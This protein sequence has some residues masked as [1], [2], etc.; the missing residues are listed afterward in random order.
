DGAMPFSNVWQQVNERGFPIN[1]VWLSAF[2]AFCMALTSLGI[3]VAYEAML[4]I[5]AIGLYVAYGLPIFFRVTLGRRSFVPGP[6]NM[7]RCGVVVGWIAVLWVVTISV[8]FSLPVSYPVT[9]ETL[10]YTPVAM[11]GLLILTVSYW[12]LSARHWF[13]GPVT[14]I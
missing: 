12:V 14:N 6:F 4:S 13:N 7:G 11:G 9:S 3:P 2:I 5:A 8:L 10:N 1:A